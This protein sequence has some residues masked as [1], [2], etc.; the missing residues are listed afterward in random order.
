[1]YV[2]A[3]VV[4]VPCADFQ[5]RVDSCSAAVIRSLDEPSIHILNIKENRMFTVAVNL[6]MA[7]NVSNH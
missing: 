1:M 7:A 4:E 6:I 3:S 2:C 5:D